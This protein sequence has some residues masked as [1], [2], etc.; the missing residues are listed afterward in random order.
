MKGEYGERGQTALD[1]TLNQVTVSVIIWQAASGVEQNH[2]PQRRAHPGTC[3]CVVT[4][5]D[6]TKVPGELRVPIS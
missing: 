2:S 5:H 1:S 3:V 4:Q 6:G